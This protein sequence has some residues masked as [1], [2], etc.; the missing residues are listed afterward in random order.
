[1][2]ERSRQRITRRVVIA[3]NDSPRIPGFL[4]HDSAA[5]F[6]IFE[7]FDGR[8]GGGE[9]FFDVAGGEV[10]TQKKLTGGEIGCAISHM[11]V[12]RE[13]AEQ[14]GSD[15]DLMLVAEDDARLVSDFEVTLTRIL[16]RVG[17]VQCLVLSEAWNDVDAG[18]WISVRRNP[19]LWLG[20]M[21]FLF[22][23]VGPLSNPLA[24]RV[25]HV[26][27]YIW[28]TGLYLISRQSAKSMLRLT[29]TK[30]RS[31]W[32]ADAY[33]YW[34]PLA[35]VDVRVCRPGLAVWDGES[36]IFGRSVAPNDDVQTVGARQRL[37]SRIAMRTRWIRFKGTL[38]T[39]GHELRGG[40]FP[41]LE[42]DPRL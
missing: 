26:S 31:N 3:L 38:K 11:K 22:R 10:I 13:F 42:T 9:A 4:E 21:S 19:T 35:G 23:P 17:H 8:S 20:S 7:A 16:R 40:K 6:V 27:N 15:E 18:S 28:G 12:I 33:H 25:G 32:V 30:G 5:S 24:Y 36:Q 1:M 29:D 41:Y 14:V 34:A 37:R 2:A 39:T